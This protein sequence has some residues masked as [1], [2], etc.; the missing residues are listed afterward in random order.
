MIKSGKI[1]KDFLRAACEC[2][3]EIKVKIIEY[4]KRL[5][6]CLFYLFYIF[7]LLVIAC[8]ILFVVRL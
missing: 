1:L 3:L 4:N 5:F 2:Q 8:I 6:C 7:S